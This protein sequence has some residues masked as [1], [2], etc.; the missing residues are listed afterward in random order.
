[1]ARSQT[2]FAINDHFQYEHVGCAYKCTYTC[3]LET[4]AHE[5]IVLLSSTLD[6]VGSQAVI[7]G[8]VA[9]RGAAG[10]VCTHMHILADHVTLS[11]S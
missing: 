7:L 8:Q 10:C 11:I 5:S 2:N 1:M 3:M 6:D 4:S 9:V